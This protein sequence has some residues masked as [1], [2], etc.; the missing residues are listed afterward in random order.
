[1]LAH[2]DFFDWRIGLA[3]EDYRYVVRIANIDDVDLVN[4]TSNVIEAMIDAFHKIPNKGNGVRL[5]WYTDM[6]V[7]TFLH[8]AALNK[9]GGSTL[10]IE[11]DLVNGGPISKFMKVPIRESTGFTG[12]SSVVS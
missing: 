5:A 2:V 1:M 11:D 6:D 10:S 12:T 7:G 4:G 8:K 3:V 9:V